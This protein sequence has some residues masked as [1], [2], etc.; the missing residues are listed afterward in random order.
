MRVTFKL[1]TILPILE[2]CLTENKFLDSD[3]FT[4]ADALVAEALGS[5]PPPEFKRLS[6]WYTEVKKDD[7]EA[8]ALLDEDEIDLFGSDDDEVDEEA[9]KV[10]AQ[11]LAEYQ[12]KKANKPK[13][14]AKTTI[15]L[16]VKPWDDETNMEALTKAV[17]GIAMD[18]LLWGGSQ[19]VA[20]GFGIK[21]LQ[22]N[23][24]VEDDKVSMDDLSDKIT[25]LEDYVQ[26]VDVA[27]MQKI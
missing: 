4:G 22:I 13:T 24:V 20:I 5:A 11:R 23:C 25:A 16:D 26:S 6:A 9:E 19:L 27:A 17:K 18:G 2:N 10:K 14:I 7:A 15:T 21:K 12:A 3:K 8:E 1:S